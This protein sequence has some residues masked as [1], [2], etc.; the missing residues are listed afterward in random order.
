MCSRRLI[1][2]GLGGPGPVAACEGTL[3]QVVVIPCGLCEKDF[4]S[5]TVGWSFHGFYSGEEDE[6]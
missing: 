4:V 2:D 6:E 5:K 1:D 3:Q